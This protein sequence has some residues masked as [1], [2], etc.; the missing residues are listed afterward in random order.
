[1]LSTVENLTKETLVLWMI[2]AG[3]PLVRAPVRA[4]F[5]AVARQFGYG[6]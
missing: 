1:M 2:V 3:F 5:V 6:L 4:F